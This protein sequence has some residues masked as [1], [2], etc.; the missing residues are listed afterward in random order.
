MIR[1]HRPY[2]VKRL[3]RKMES[4]YARRRLR[5]QFERLGKGG[6]FFKPWHVELFGP[7]ISM[8]DFATIIAAPDRRVRFCVWPAEAE[9]GEI[10]IGDYGLICPGVRIGS[11]AGVFIGDNCMIA[12]GAYITDSDW[13][14]LY[15]RVSTGTASPVTISENV[16]IGDGAMICKGVSVGRNSVIGAGAVVARDVPEDA[17]AAGNPAGVVKR[18]DPEKP[19]VPRERWFA[20]PVQLARELDRWDRDI[21]RENTAGHWIRHV[22]APKRGD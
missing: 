1:D 11:A 14:G 15:D 18:L 17:V 6:T 13:H 10:R 19:R 16:W 12:S 3:Y 4:W 9:S 21:L 7:R 20:D 8:G 22:L 2:Y 5:P